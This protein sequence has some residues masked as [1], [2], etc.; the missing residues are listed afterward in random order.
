MSG[1]SYKEWV[2]DFYPLRT[3]REDM[4]AYYSSRFGAVEINMTFR[5]QPPETTM[6]K[7]REAVNEEF[8]FTLKANQLITH[9][10]RLVDV[11]ADVSEFVKFART[12]GERLGPVLFQ[13]PPTLQFDAGVLDTFCAELPP[14]GLYAFEPRHESFAGSDVDDVLRRHGVAR[15]LNDALFDPQT[16]RVTAPVAYFRFHRERYET[17]DIAERASIV[18]AMADGGADVYAFFAHEDNPESV[19]PA[20]ALQEQ[21]G[22]SGE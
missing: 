17:S 22:G 6:P 20:L 10:R 8:R 14:G 9:W 2:G 12:L 15:C 19:R 21:V 1:F 16:Y 13:V 18:R 11:S 5:R 4:L 7:W 3:K